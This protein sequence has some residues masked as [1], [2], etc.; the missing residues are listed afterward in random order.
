M[1]Q[2]LEELVLCGK[3]ITSSALSADT[4]FRQR[5]PVEARFKL[6]SQI[7]MVEVGLL[8]VRTRIATCE[9]ISRL[10]CAFVNP[11]DTGRLPR[12]DPIFLW[13][14]VQVHC[15][16]RRRRVAAVERLVDAGLCVHNMRAIIAQSS[17][18]SGM[19]GAQRAP[20]TQRR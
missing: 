5:I 10:L 16:R 20:I 1:H 15:T 2:C 8:R 9:R 19:T 17:A 4:F 3:I 14:D 13:L 6:F 11:K 18:C 7:A 12:R